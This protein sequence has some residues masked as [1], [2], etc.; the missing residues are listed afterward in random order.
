MLEVIQRFNDPFSD[1]FEEIPLFYDATEKEYYLRVRDI[2]KLTPECIEELP[3]GCNEHQ[4][5]LMEQEHG[6]HVYLLRA[7]NGF[8]K[9]G[10]SKVLDDRIKQ[11][12]VQLPYELELICAIQTVNPIGLEEELHTRFREKRKRGE[13]FN[14]DED[15]VTYFAVLSKIRWQAE[16]FYKYY[17]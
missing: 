5:E 12:A 9:I 2:P 8:Y 10:Q 11:L 7:D 4:R 15:D 6:G 17:G 14:L 16:F 13:W 3:I 1:K